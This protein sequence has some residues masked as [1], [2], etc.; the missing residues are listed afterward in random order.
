MFAPVE[1]L[2][3]RENLA[4]L[5]VLAFLSA[6]LSPAAV[7]LLVL[8]PTICQASPKKHS[9]VSVFIV[10]GLI[11]SLSITQWIWITVMCASSNYLMQNQVLLAK[12]LYLVASFSLILLSYNS[13]HLENQTRVSR[14][15]V[16]HMTVVPGECRPC[17]LLQMSMTTFQP[18]H[19]A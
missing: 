12:K 14:R 7:N 6:R 2:P 8:L 19:K 15:Q 13:F 18:S 3:T 10:C 4:A 17:L 5:K 16:C 9:T 11:L 1:L